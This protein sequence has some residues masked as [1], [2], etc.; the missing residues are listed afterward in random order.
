M[1]ARIL[2]FNT[3]NSAKR[4][5]ECGLEGF[6]RR[7]RTAAFK[8]SAA[9]QMCHKPSIRQL[10]VVFVGEN[11]H[12][13][14]TVLEGTKRAQIGIHS[15]CPLPLVYHKRSRTH[16]HIGQVGSER[17]KRILHHAVCTYRW[18][19]KLPEYTCQSHG[20]E[21]NGQIWPV[22]VVMR[23]IFCQWFGNYWFL[24]ASSSTFLFR[25]RSRW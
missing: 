6:R 11:F 9:E 17:Q 16:T 22:I 7:E 5:Y 19:G 20:Y 18:I 13:I 24:L 2:T 3:A 8:G 21:I 23:Q 12:V 14:H 10:V 15:Q 4:S 25:R 1:M